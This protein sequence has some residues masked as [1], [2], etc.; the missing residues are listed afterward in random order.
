[1]NQDH[2]ATR[3]PPFFLS[4]GYIPRARRLVVAPPLPESQRSASQ[5]VANLLSR[6]EEAHLGAQARNLQT[7]QRRVVSSEE[8]CIE[9]HVGD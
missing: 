8:T 7:K 4:H 3:Y 5:W 6:L 9:L 2:Q 1:M